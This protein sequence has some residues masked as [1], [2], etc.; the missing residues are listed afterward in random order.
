MAGFLLCASIV[1]ESNTGC[2]LGTPD[3]TEQAADESHGGLGPKKNCTPDLPHTFCGASRRVGVSRARL[4]SLSRADPPPSAGRVTAFLHP[5]HTSLD[6]NQDDPPVTAAID[7]G[8][9]ER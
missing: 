1:V 3:L 4:T 9:S 8:R 6:G 2:R 7:V 5:L